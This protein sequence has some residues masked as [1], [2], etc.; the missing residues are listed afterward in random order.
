[1]ELS[2]EWKGIREIARQVRASSGAVHRR[3]QD[4]KKHGNE[5]LAAK[6]TPG[7]PKKLTA[8]SS[9]SMGMSE[10]PPVARASFDVIVLDVDNGPEP[11]SGDSHEGLYTVGGIRQNHDRLSKGGAV[12]LWSGFRSEKCHVNAQQAGFDVACVPVQVGLR[13]HGHVIY[14]CR[15]QGE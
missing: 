2:K 8:K 15:R 1:V 7:R 3:L 9:L 13:E 14:V 5:A 12:L 4:W 11:V 10:I 6:P